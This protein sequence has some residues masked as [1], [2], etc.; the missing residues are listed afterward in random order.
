M[1]NNKEEEEDLYGVSRFSSA[2]SRRGPVCAQVSTRSVM[3]LLLLLLALPLVKRHPWRVTSQTIASRMVDLRQQQAWQLCHRGKI[4]PQQKY[5]NNTLHLYKFCFKWDSLNIEP[6]GHRGVQ[7]ASDWLL[8]HVNDP[9]LDDNSPREYILYACPTGALLEELEAFWEKSLDDCGW[10]GAHNFMPHVTLVSFFKVP[11][12]SIQ[13][14]MGIFVQACISGAG[15]RFRQCKLTPIYVAALAVEPHVKSLHLTLA[16]QF[17]TA[18]YIA[19]QNL[20]EELPAATPALWEL[21][22][23][24]RDARIAGN[25]VHKVRY[26][27]TPREPD[28]LELRI[29]DYIYLS[30]E[31]IASSTDG[32]VEGVSW[33]TVRGQRQLSVHQSGLGGSHSGSGSELARHSDATSDCDDQ[34]RSLYENVSDTM[35]VGEVYIMRHG[36]RVDFTF[37]TWIPYCFDDSGAYI[38]KDLNMP[39][40]VPKRKNGPHGFLKDCPLTNI[41]EMQARLVGEA[42]KEA[43]V[44]IQHV[45]CSPSLRCIQTCTSVLKGL[46]LDSVAIR[47]EP[48]LFEWLGWYPDSLPDFLDQQELREAGFHIHR[49]YQPFVKLEELQVRRESCEQFYMR[50]FY[51]AQSVLKSTEDIGGNILLVGHAATLDSCSRQLVGGTPRTS[52]EMRSIITKIPYCSTALVQV[53][54]DS[55]WRLKE[56]SFP[57]I[58]HCSVVR[59]D[60]RVMQDKNSP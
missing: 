50:S 39:R 16:Y 9:L 13:Y 18:H 58:T 12:D 26:S 34:R 33:L 56:P 11:D 41:G 32:W 29:G 57:P 28:E 19:L 40:S 3:L 53:D 4:Q 6:T 15:F 51:L 42:M 31:A 22:L 55:K 44:H 43:N 25:Q 59:F 30:G 14:W 23:Y 36:E 21:R 45:F 24:S 35:D 5:Q 17:P 52:Q 54:D 37:G 20:V 49:S 1:I 60:W 2:A 48:G 46:G 7:L 8:A 27:H 47:L 38:R 10:N